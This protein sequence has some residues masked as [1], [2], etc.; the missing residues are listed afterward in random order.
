MNDEEISDV[1]ESLYAH[2]GGAQRSLASELG[3]QAV[4][5][6]IL[7]YLRRCNRFSNTLLILC[8]YLGQTKGTVSTSVSLLEKKGLLYKQVDALDKRKQ[9]LLLTDSGRVLAE[10]HRQYWAQLTR[11]ISTLERDHVLAAMETTQQALQR[12][13]LRP[14][15]GVCRQCRHL[16][17]S[18]TAHRCDVMNELLQ[19]GERDQVCAFHQR[20]RIVETSV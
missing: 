17:S 2:I 10:R 4:H 18:L 11:S 1:L 7:Y 14:A 16:Y 9:H 20:K 3:L 6:Q 5:L 12:Q 15:F 19:G 8:D 13:S